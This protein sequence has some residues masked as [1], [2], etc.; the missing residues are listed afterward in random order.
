MCGIVGALSLTGKALFWTEA[1]ILR[2][3]RT[4]R[5]RGPDDQ[6]AWADPRG[7]CLLGHARLKV[8]D[9]AHG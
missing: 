3:A 2:A 8:I 5:H 4:L 7:V 1:D 9:L 6:T